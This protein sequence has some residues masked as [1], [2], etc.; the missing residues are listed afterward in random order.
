MLGTGAVAAAAAAAPPGA[1]EA[2]GAVSASGGGSGPNAAAPASAPEQ[3][4]QQGGAAGGGGGDEGVAH[5]FAT[6]YLAAVRRG[7]AKWADGGVQELLAQDIK[8]LAADRQRFV[9]RAAVVRRL[10]QG[11]CFGGASVGV[12]TVSVNT[13]QTPNRPL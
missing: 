11:G 7:D 10:N 9:G 4:Q 12:C 3:Q 6:A 2:A 5:A 13:V 1:G 8:L